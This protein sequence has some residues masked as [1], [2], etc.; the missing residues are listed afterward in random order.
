MV[1]DSLH[2]GRYKLWLDEQKVVPTIKALTQ[3]FEDIRE[4][5]LDFFKNK[6]ETDDFD[7][8]DNLTRRIV[9]KLAAYSIEH[10]RNHHQSEEVAEMVKEMFKLEAKNG[11]E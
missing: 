11:H 1:F 4:D 6:I 2:P 7:K 8:V 5:E 9:N 3:K 10:L